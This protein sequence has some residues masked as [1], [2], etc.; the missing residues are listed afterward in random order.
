M[1]KPTRL[2]L[3][4]E[5]AEFLNEETEIYSMLH[6]ALELLVDGSDFTTGWVFFIDDQGHHELV[7]DVH[8][9][10]ALLKKDCQYMK[11]GSCW[12]VQAYHKKKL[13]KASNIINCSR[14]NLANKK[15]V[16]ETDDITHHATVPLRS[17][18]EQFGLLNVATPETKRYSE[19]DLELLES[20]AFQIGSAIKRIY[21]TDQEKEAARI[22]ERN[23]LARDLHDSVN[24]MLFSLKV[25]AHAAQNLTQE[26]MSLKAFKTIESTSQQAVNEMRALIW[27]LKPIGLEHGLVQALKQYAKMLDMSLD[28]EV[29]GLIDVSHSIEENIY[30][31]IQEAMNNTRKHTNTNHIKLKLEQTE[32]ELIVDII[33]QG[34]GF[35]VS[36]KNLY[37]SHGINNMKQRAHMIHGQMKLASTKQEGTSIHLKI[38]L[39]EEG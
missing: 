4:K 32:T 8:L 7:S 19:E 3:L 34:E 33:D 5:I 28:V 31:I 9:P 37:E 6:G 39:K 11:E 38:P 21:L 23:R 1:E 30:R 10:G 35:D 27:Q 14:I 18:N 12:C 20:V 13:T 29:S 22:S 24:Q 17:G 15:Y 26:E 16:D 25:T 2:A 36:S